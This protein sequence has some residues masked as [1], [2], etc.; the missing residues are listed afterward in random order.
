MNLYFLGFTDFLLSF[1][2]DGISKKRKN[3]LLSGAL[4]SFCVV[5]EIFLCTSFQTLLRRDFVTALYLVL[6]FATKPFVYTPC[7]THKQYFHL[8][9]AGAHLVCWHQRP[10]GAK[11]SNWGSSS[12]LSVVATAVGEW[13]W[14]CRVFLAQMEGPSFSKV[15]DKKVVYFTLSG[16]FLAWFT[17]RLSFEAVQRSS[18]PSF[19]L[20]LLFPIACLT[21]NFSSLLIIPQ[22]PIE[23]AQGKF[24]LQK[25]QNCVWVAE[26]FRGLSCLYKPIS[27][28][29]IINRRH[30]FPNLSHSIH[31]MVACCYDNEG[32]SWV[33]LSFWWLPKAEI[34]LLKICLSFYATHGIQACWGF[35]ITTT[36]CGFTIRQA[37]LS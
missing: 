28:P 36:D 19:Y 7:Y 27:L 2:F 10:S 34:I 8:E 11:V 35:Q 1:S 32:L 26:L 9:D 5:C 16:Q 13:Q 6:Y 29:L 23:G 4:L 15:F 31:H 18:L 12:V 30:F 24:K 20:Y 33:V 22:N 17:L 37:M 3:A 21:F 14:L 25:M